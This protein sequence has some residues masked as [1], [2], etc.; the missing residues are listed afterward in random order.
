MTFAEIVS[1]IIAVAILC[2]FLSP[3][4]RRLESWFYKIFRSKSGRTEK[5]VID[6][7][8]YSKKKGKKP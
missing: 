3:L 5:R 1:A 6:I 2:F 7:T 4:Q 8:D